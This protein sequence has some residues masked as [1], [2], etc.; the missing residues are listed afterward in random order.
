MNQPL[1]CMTLTGKTLEENRQL[2]NKYY[3]YI[4][5]VELRVDHLTEQEQ[6]YARKFPAM[7]HMPCIL[8]I[9]RDIDGGLFDGSEFS[10]ICLFSRAL[11]FADQDRTKNFAYVDFE[12]DFHIPSIQDAAMAFGVRIIRSCHSMKEPILNIRERCDIMRKTGYEIPKIAFMPHSL[13][14]VLNLLKEGEAMT[15]YEHILCAMGPEGFPSR[16]LASRTNSFLTYVS[17][18]EVIENTKAIGH[19]DPVTINEMYHF[20]SINQETALYGIAGWPL[21]KTSSPE[22]HN[23]GYE[24]KKINAVY[25]PYRSQ[26]IS[27]T[28]TFCEGA[29][30]KGLSVTIPHKESVMY[31]INEQSPEV[32]QIGACNTLVRKNNKWLG[33]NTDAPGF[34]RALEEFLG[35]VK[36]KHKKVAVIGAGGAAKAIVY[37]LKQ[38]G[39]RVCIFNRTVEAAMQ[40][41]DKYGFNYCQLDAHCAAK[42]DE[43]SNLIVQTTSVGMN[44]EGPSNAEND[45]IYFY[46]FRGNELLFDIIYEPSTTP[47]MRR[48]ELSGCRVC[49]GYKM[50]EY[51]AYEQFKLFTGRSYE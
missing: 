39:A 32:A 45:P 22:I 3:K 12:D 8:T 1:V 36:I 7:I 46:D 51:Q 49:K 28:L 17:P 10:R 16:V 30:V 42:L 19:I 20:K 26:L 43:Y 5:L 4:D 2:V 31:Y 27:D 47:V 44:S 18:E 35:P 37:V 48:A 40:L 33:Y 21:L 15:Q 23:K 50:L 24:E 29:G 34:R 14:D 38:M 9:R 13:S 6:L 11:A 25:I 41:A